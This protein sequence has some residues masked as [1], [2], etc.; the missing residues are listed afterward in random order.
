MED[1]KNSKPGDN[2]DAPLITTTPQ[3]INENRTFSDHKPDS[4]I[5][6]A[7]EDKWLNDSGPSKKPDPDKK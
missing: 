6:K 2:T 7:Q 3:I 5:K 1:N 4:S